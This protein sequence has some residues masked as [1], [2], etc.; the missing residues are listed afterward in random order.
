MPGTGCVHYIYDHISFS[1]QAWRV[2]IIILSIDQGSD[3]QLLIAILGGKDRA[4]VKIQVVL[5]EIKTL[6]KV[7]LVDFL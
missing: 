6:L 2:E 4:R 1:Q 5:I 3:R 7:C